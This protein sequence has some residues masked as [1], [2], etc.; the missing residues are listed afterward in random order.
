MSCFSRSN[1]SLAFLRCEDFCKRLAS[2]SFRKSASSSFSL[3]DGSR[4]R[5][6]RARLEGLERFSSPDSNLSLSA[7]RFAASAAAD[8]LASA[9]TALLA[10]A[11]RDTEPRACPSPPVPSPRRRVSRPAA[12]EP[13][14]AAPRH[15]PGALRVCAARSPCP[16]TAWRARRAWLDVDDVRARPPRRRARRRRAPIVGSGETE[17]RRGL[18]ARRVI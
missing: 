10:F 5:W 3:S 18:V 14:R 2:M 1:V 16:G 13:R 11:A 6:P 15:L 12:P 8:A 9:T 7:P 4:S 17:G